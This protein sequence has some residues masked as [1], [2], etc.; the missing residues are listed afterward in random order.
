MNW[1]KENKFLTGYMIVMVI[2]L[3]LLGYEVFS[4]SGAYDDALTAYTAKAGEYNRLR[5]L[6]PF[7]SKQ[8]LDQY[9]EQKVSAR[10]VITDFQIDLSKKEFPLTPMSPSVFQDKL[11]AAVT[12]VQKKAADANVKLDPKF[13]LG[14]EGYETKPP[15]QEAAAPLGRQLEAIEWVV[16]QCIENQAFS[17][18]NLLRTDLP[19]EGNGTGGRGRQAGGGRPNPGGPGGPGSPGKGPGGGGASRKDLVHYH[20]FVISVICKQ[21]KMLA[22]LNSI[23]GAKAPQFYV[24]RQIRIRNEKEKGPAKATPA[25]GGEAG[26]GAIQ[27]IVGEEMVEFAAD[28]DI[29][30]FTAPTEESSVAEKSSPAEK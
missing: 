18:A 28:I 1:A 11:K 4:A 3:G 25:P 14:F 16:N 29:V 13:F 26:K 2:G 27:Y 17:I 15:T 24:I 8:N 22:I 10:K 19:E 30:N 5:H 21:G 23:V 7:P 9:D 20:P 6:Q 12:D